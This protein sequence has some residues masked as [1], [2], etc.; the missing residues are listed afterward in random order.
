M[1]EW[2]ALNWRGKLCYTL[3]AINLW[4]AIV[5]AFNG[6]WIA[7]Y[8]A[9]LAA[10]LGLCTFDKRNQHGDKNKLHKTRT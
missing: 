10:I 9:C 1:I 5:L 2:Q 4:V 8:Q 7:V 6:Q 3:S